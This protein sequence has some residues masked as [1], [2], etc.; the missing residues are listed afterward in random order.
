MEVFFLFWFLLAALVAAFAN[1]RGRS[2]LGFFLIALLLSPLLAFIIL[3]VIKDLKAE[4]DAK[5]VEAGRRREEEARRD[6]LLTVRALGGGA[7]AQLAAPAEPVAMKKCPF[8]AEDV[9]AAAIK[10]KHC[11]SSLSATA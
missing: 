7:P 11:G 10:C 4:E 1:G 6:E 8:C 5:L 3:L 9:R 2:G